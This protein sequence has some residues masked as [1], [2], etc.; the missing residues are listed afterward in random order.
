MPSLLTENEARWGYPLW[1]A[2][3]AALL[4]GTPHDALAEPC[5]SVDDCP[6]D[7]V[8]EAG[9]CAAPAVADDDDGDA[10]DEADGTPREEAV[11][12]DG[13]GDPALIGTGI[14][15]LGLGVFG[16]AVGIVG[17]VGGADTGNEYVAANA[18][19]TVQP[20]TTGFP[21]TSNG[22]LQIAGGI[23]LGIGGALALAGAIVIPVGVHSSP[24]A[25]D[26]AVT[27]EP[28]LGPGHTGLRLRF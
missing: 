5:A 4:L 24:S 28:L 17:I 8:C 6:G 11:A 27:V 7:E 12:G 10:G 23:M 19:G 1:A 2:C 25:G 13:G 20:N 9:Q 16:T 18:T 26:A 14:G 15:L 3:T 21:S 22:G